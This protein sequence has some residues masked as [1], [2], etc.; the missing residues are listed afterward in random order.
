MTCIVGLECSDGAV[1]AGDFCGSNGFTYHTMI[2]SKVFKHSQMLFGYTSTF[3]FGQIIEH[4]LDDNTLYPPTEPEQ[5]YRWLVKTFVPKIRQVFKDEEYRLGDGCNAVLVI[6][7]QVWELQND[8]SV[9]RN[10]VGLTVVGSGEYHAQS[11]ILTQLL[12]NHRNS[13]PTMAEA[14]KIIEL[15]YNVTASFVSSVS[16]KV[17]VIKDR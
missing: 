10:D 5:T 13:K 7:G 17:E 8:L 1:I 2:P 11:S 15:A 16:S 3:R 9:L 6:N 14:E 12:M 4:I